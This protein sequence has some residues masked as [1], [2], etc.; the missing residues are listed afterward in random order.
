M[1]QREHVEPGQPH[2]D[3]RI[4]TK[5]SLEK[6]STHKHTKKYTNLH[7]E[8]H[9]SNGFAGEQTSPEKKSTGDYCIQPDL[10]N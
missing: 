4:Q 3:Q 5:T 2:L 7:G 10:E 9:K 6:K 1:K 8:L